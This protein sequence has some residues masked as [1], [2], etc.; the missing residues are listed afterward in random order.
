MQLRVQKCVS[1]NMLHLV[2][3]CGLRQG[4]DAS[5]KAGQIPGERSSAYHN[6]AQRTLRSLQIQSTPLV[7]LRMSL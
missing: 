1:R 4:P 6:S 2:G 3:G 5:A 7:P